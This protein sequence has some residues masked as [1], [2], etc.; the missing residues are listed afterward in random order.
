MSLPVL[1]L[2]GISLDQFKKKKLCG[3]DQHSFLSVLVFD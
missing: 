3:N 1:V 2:V